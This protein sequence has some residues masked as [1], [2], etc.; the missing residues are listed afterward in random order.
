MTN[1][2]HAP[3]PAFGRPLSDPNW[4]VPGAAPKRPRGR[5]KRLIIPETGHLMY[6]EKPEEFSRAVIIFI[7]SNGP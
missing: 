2:H 6:L 3:T 7:D 5:S 4:L 1:D